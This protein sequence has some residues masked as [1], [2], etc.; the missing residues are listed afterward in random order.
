MSEL[1]RPETSGAD[2]STSDKSEELISLLDEYIDALESKELEWVESHKALTERVEA[3]AEKRVAKLEAA[4]FHHAKR[5]LDL[6]ESRKR[7]E[8]LQLYKEL[9]DKVMK[10]GIAKDVHWIEY[11]A[12]QANQAPQEGES[13]L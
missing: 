7:V 13:E 12:L 10:R 5:L 6:S 11:A 8:E 1:K 3:Y 9:L 2:I 4:E